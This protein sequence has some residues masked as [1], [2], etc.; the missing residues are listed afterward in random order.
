MNMVPYENLMKTTVIDQRA[1]NRNQMLWLDGILS[2][3]FWEVE[4]MA[5]SV[6]ELF[7]DQKGRL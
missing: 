7:G 3:S 4:N 5:V 2:C 6:K 1:K